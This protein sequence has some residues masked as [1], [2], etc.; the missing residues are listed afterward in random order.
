M[1]KKDITSSKIQ[2]GSTQPEVTIGHKNG[3]SEMKTGSSMRV[4][5]QGD[6]AGSM[7]ICNYSNLVISAPVYTFGVNKLQDF[8]SKYCNIK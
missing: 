6:I 4:W 1:E 2:E 5:W 3:S 8:R 7:D